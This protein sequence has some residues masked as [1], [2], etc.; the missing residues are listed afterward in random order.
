MPPNLN[1]L[2][3][4]QR[5]HLDSPRYGLPHK[6]QERGDGREPENR[7]DFQKVEE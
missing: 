4:T 7:E 5:E 3:Q 2:P 6:K 1:L